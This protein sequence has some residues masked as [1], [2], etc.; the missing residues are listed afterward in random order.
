MLIKPLKRNVIVEPIRA[1]KTT[2]SGI[3]LSSSL[4]PDTAKIVSIGSEVD[5]V[6]VGDVVLLDWKKARKIDSLDETYIVSI[7]YVIFVYE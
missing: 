2:D 5:E 1:S 7:D 6:E 3:I 4:D